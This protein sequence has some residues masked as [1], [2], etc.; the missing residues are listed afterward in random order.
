MTKLSSS[1]KHADLLHGEVR[2]V[3][4]SPVAQAAVERVLQMSE[5][6][7]PLLESQTPL[8]QKAKERFAALG[9]PT[10]KLEDWKYTRL[11]QFLQEDFT[12]PMAKMTL[13]INDIEAFLPDFS[14]YSVVFVD[15]QFA[16]TLSDDLP[17]GVSLKLMQPTAQPESEWIADAEDFLAEPFAALNLLLAPSGLQLEVAPNTQVDLPIF[18]LQIQTQAHTSVQMHHQICIGQGAEV[19]LLQETVALGESEPV[20]SNLVTEIEV[21][22]NAFCRQLILQQLPENHY[23]FET[24]FIAQAKHSHFSSHYIATGAALSRHQNHLLMADESVET[25]Q[26]SA[27]IASGKQLMDSRTDTTHASTHGVSRQLHKYVLAGESVGVFDGMIYVD[28]G[29]IKTDGQMD[30][31]NLILSNSAKMDAKPKLEIYADDVKCAHGSAT[32]QM[33]KDQVFYLQARGIKRPEAVA[34]ITQAFAMEPL[35][36][37]PSAELRKL[38]QLAIQQKLDGLF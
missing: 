31:K 14:V 9:F 27:C 12:L 23:Y 5:G 30:N 4:M 2:P 11:T 38:A 33:D 37:V 1:T 6:V 20:W 15:G 34:L 35:E 28:R 3:K 36:D 22:E 32:G 26:N 21:A 29:A 10:Q 24:Q 17:E 16:P 18:I 8:Y 13:S 7:T 25:I 19:N